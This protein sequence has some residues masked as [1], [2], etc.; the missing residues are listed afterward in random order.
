M[1]YI[2]QLAVI[3]A[4]S[5]VGE[6]LSSIIPLPVPAGIY[7][8][9][10]L[11]VMLI[12]KILPLSAVENTG[13]FLIEIMPLMFIPA[14]VGLIDSYGSI[15]SSIVVYLVITVVSTVFVMAVSGLVTQ[16]IIC[17]KR[18]GDDAK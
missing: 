14:A 13:D 11:F 16:M 4:V 10:I 3:L 12:S 17:L 6:I 7:G 18:K 8:I 2:K 1:K 5:F 9:V 15:R